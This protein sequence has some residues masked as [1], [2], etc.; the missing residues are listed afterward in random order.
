MTRTSEQTLYRFWRRKEL[1]YVGV[2]SEAYKRARQHAHS[3]KWWLDADR[4][5]FEKFADR[6]AVL[7]AEKKAIQTEK[8]K[9]NVIYNKGKHVT[10]IAQ[11]LNSQRLMALRILSDMTQKEIQNLQDELAAAKRTILQQAE[12]LLVKHNQLDALILG[13]MDT[14]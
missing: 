2:S 10:P 5:T 4:V 3:A 9:H 14:A 13:R 11:Q 8:P 6:N 1:L 12:L 7:A